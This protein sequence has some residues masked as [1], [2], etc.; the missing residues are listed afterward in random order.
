[1]AAEVPRQIANAHTVFNIAN[2]LVFIGFATLF[3]RIA[4]KLVPDKPLEDE[5][6][7]ARRTLADAAET[8][9]QRLI[10]A[11]Q[12]RQAPVTAAEQEARIRLPRRFQPTCHA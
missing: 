3:A 10:E 11:R 4:Q 8:I 12:V 1:M 7:L 5:A 9:E 2:T 6:D